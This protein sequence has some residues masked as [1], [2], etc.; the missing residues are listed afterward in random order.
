MNFMFVAKQ[1]LPKGN[2]ELWIIGFSD[3]R[4]A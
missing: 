2:G 3:T 4:I 1:R